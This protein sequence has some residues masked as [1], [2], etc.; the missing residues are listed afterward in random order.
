MIDILFPCNG[1]TGD[2]SNQ[3]ENKCNEDSLPITFDKQVFFFPV[4]AVIVTDVPGNNANITKKHI[5]LIHLKLLTKLYFVL[6]QKTSSNPKSLMHV[7][8][9]LNS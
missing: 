2:L 4:K 3:I 5:V 1:S 6:L 7:L 9:D 8:T